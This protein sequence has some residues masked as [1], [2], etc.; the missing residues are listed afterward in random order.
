MVYE[1]LTAPPSE[2]YI[3]GLHEHRKELW[4]RAKNKWKSIDQF[5][6]RKYQVWPERRHRGRPEYR[7]STPA[8]IID[9]A[10]D[11]QM[12]YDPNVSR[13]PHTESDESQ[14]KA[15]RIENAITAIFHDSSLKEPNLVWKQ[16]G[17]YLLQY[18]YAVIEGPHWSFDEGPMSPQQQEYETDEDFDE[19]VKHYGRIKSR[20]NP[21]RIHCPHPSTILLDPF[22]KQPDEA[23]KMSKINMLDLKRLAVRKILSRDYARELFVP[24]G[25]ED[26]TQLEI[27]EHWDISW[28]SIKVMETGQLLYQEPN[29]WGYVPFTHAFA[30]F[31]TEPTDAN[32][33]NPAHFAVGL[34]DHVRESIRIQAQNESAKHAATMTAAFRSW[35]T[36]RD[37]TATAAEE[38]EE[39][40]MLQGQKED[41]WQVNVPEYGRWMFQSGQE[42]IADIE[43]GT[44]TRTLSGRREEGVTTVGQQVILSTAA[45]RKFQAPAR[46]LEHMATIIA[47]WILQAVSVRGETIG[48]GRHQLKPSDIE[49]DY[50]IGVTFELVDPALQL[51]QRQLGLQEV[52][53]GF[54][55]LETYWHTDLRLSDTSGEW[56]RITEEAV[57]KHPIISGLMAAR[58]AKQLGFP[59]AA[60][61][62]EQQAAQSLSE[63]E[64]RVAQVQPVNEAGLVGPDGQPIQSEPMEAA[65]PNG[66]SAGLREILTADIVKPGRT[67]AG[68]L[69]LGQ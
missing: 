11:T 66:V 28:H 64:Q 23:I 59:Q 45:S 15:D 6:Q 8:H 39:G 34:L 21:I 60:A 54:K 1:N 5:V 14:L 52:N 62:F 55:S 18:G 57:K 63:I 24:E 29:P 41:Y 17:R 3:D 16:A 53:A 32:D 2:H 51:Q 27:M 19:R 37:D 68:G 40:R 48:V 65:S 7:P 47:R 33:M 56:D 4:R 10:A 26:W 35:G 9:H 36:T 69:E 46:Q 31:G 49:S 42:V 58:A 50:T 43:A 67:R 44:Y 20:H 12:A 13:P 22:Q 38:I 25:C 61:V 30:G